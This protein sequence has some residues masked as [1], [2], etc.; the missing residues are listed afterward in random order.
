MLTCEVECALAHSSPAVGRFSDIH[1]AA[2]VITGPAVAGWG[3][4]SHVLEVLLTSAG[5]FEN[6]RLVCPYTF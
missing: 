1:L 6:S 3:R 2:A 5:F 4:I